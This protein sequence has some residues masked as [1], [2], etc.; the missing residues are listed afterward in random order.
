MQPHMVHNVPPMVPTHAQSRNTP[1][2]TASNQDRATKLPQP[3]PTV[4][5][6]VTLQVIHLVWNMD[7][8]ATTVTKRDILE[9]VAGPSQARVVRGRD[10][11]MGKW[12]ICM[13]VQ[14]RIPHIHL[15]PFFGTVEMDQISF[16]A[17]YFFHVE[18][19]SGSQCTAV[20]MTI[21][22][23]AFLNDILRQPP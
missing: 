2:H 14:P 23:M 22:N 6:M 12:P 1:H 19:D 9:G 21:F 4:G 11:Q 17:P 15:M 16:Q 13:H 8:S 5:G 20:T 10:C 3:V 7:N 18:L